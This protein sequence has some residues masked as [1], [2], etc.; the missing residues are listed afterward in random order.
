MYRSIT[1]QIFTVYISGCLCFKIS[2]SRMSFIR[3]ILWK[4]R[5]RK[6]LRPCLWH[7]GSLSSFFTKDRKSPFWCLKKKKGRGGRINGTKSCSCATQQVANRNSQQLGNKS[8]LVHHVG[9]VWH[10]QAAKLWTVLEHN[11]SNLRYQHAFSQSGFQIHKKPGG[12]GT[13][14]RP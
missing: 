6:D 9:H 13:S 3:V 8:L 10:I 5:T 11:V 7:I 1:V 12:E 2:T 4:G 14:G